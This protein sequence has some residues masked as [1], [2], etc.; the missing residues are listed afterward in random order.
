MP[1]YDVRI[2]SEN[3]TV[4]FLKDGQPVQNL[5]DFT[6][7][8]FKGFDGEF[9]YHTS[10]MTIEDGEQVLRS[11]NFTVDGDDVVSGSQEEVKGGESVAKHLFDTLKKQDAAR[12]LANLFGRKKDKNKDKKKERPKTTEHK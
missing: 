1:V 5:Q 9:R 6:T 10:Y 7:S 3:K 2:D 8:F 12:Q 4:S 11:V